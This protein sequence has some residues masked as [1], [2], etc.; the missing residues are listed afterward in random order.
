M[1]KLV[2]GEDQFSIA[3][4][5]FGRD[6]SYQSRAFTYFIDHIYYKFLDLLTDNLQ[7]WYES[8]FL[9]QSRAAIQSKLASL[10]FTF[11]EDELNTI[12]AFIDCNCMETCRVGG[13]PRSDGPDAERWQC[14]VTIYS[15]VILVKVGVQLRSRNASSTIWSTT[16][17]NIFSLRMYS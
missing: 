7:W 11:S 13:G 15:I 4:N 3:E 2:S 1:H 14:N 10:G 16:L 12:F 17:E 5:V 6:Q 9:E 8:G